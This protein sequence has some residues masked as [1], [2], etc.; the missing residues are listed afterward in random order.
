MEQKRKLVLCCMSMVS[1]V[2]L[3]NHEV[4]ADA[5][6][7]GYGAGNDSWS[8]ACQGELTAA[9]G[10]ASLSQ[11]LSFPMTETLRAGQVT[12][13]IDV[14]QLMKQGLA[15]MENW[16]TGAVTNEDGLFLPA[17]VDVQDSWLVEHTTTPSGGKPQTVT[18][19]ATLLAWQTLNGFPV[20][21]IR[22]AWTEPVCLKRT[23]DGTACLEGE[24]D[25]ESTL[26]FAYETKVMVKTEFTAAGSLAY[27]KGAANVDLDVTC[28]ITATLK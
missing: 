19:T 27:T 4:Y 10:G 21:K 15:G 26:Y 12:R 7:L 13:Q 6:V 14:Q 11:K 16:A 18:A 9:G 3:F 25:C 5:K 22:C 1:L 2:A 20:A 24:L 17:A 23:D 28:A 8:Y